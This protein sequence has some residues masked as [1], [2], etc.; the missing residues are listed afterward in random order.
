MLGNLSRR[1]AFFRL[2]VLVC[3]GVEVLGLFVVVEQLYFIWL[4]RKKQIE[5][6]CFGELEGILVDLNRV[7]VSIVALWARRGIKSLTIDEV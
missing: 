2:V 5:L 1:L 3:Y 7:L 6:L 4:G